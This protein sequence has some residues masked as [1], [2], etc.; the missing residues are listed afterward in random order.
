MISTAFYNNP[1]QHHER[2]NGGGNQNGGRETSLKGDE[3]MYLRSA[4]A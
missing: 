2:P 4:Q 1:T 3:L